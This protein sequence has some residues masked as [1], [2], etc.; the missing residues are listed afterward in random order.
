MLDGLAGQ[1]NSAEGQRMG[2]P[3]W[4]GGATGDERVHVCRGFVANGR[5]HFH[6]L[7]SK[8]HILG[9]PTLSRGLSP[10]AAAL[11]VITSISGPRD[12]HDYRDLTAECWT[13]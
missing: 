2:N 8:F 10:L 3:Y 12:T 13:T 5:A 11:P 1:Q 6:R 9:P 4:L 7:R